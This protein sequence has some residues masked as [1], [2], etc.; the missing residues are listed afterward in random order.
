[1]RALQSFSFVQSARAPSILGGLSGSSPLSGSSCLPSE[2]ELSE[3]PALLSGTSSPASSPAP[4]LL[5]APFSARLL[6]A[7]SASVTL[8]SGFLYLS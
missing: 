3:P 1:M 5:L 4:S 8:A 7:F 2:S 6:P